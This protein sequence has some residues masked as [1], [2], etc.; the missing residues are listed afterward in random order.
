MN[1][2]GK[3]LLASIEFEKAVEINKFAI[4]PAVIAT[5]LM[6]AWM[7]SG[8][9]Q[10]VAEAMAQCDTLVDSAKEII[11]QLTELNE[12]YGFGHIQSDADKLIANLKLMVDLY[13]SIS[14]PISDKETDKN[15]LKTLKDNIS[16]FIVALSE[17]ETQLQL[18]SSYLTENKGW[19]T[20]STEAL[21]GVG[22]SFGLE[23]DTISAMRAISNFYVHVGAKRIELENT[24]KKLADKAKAQITQTPEMSL[25]NSFT[26]EEPE[27]GEELE[28]MPGALDTSTKSKLTSSNLEEFADINF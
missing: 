11:E 7:V 27:D 15:K 8:A 4:A 12:D 14:E 23:T 17:S 19:G 25:E 21:R 1:K 18:V 24:L 22:M 9:M 2:T 10:G 6:Y 20:K 26:N 13:P 28:P 3:I 5:Y 16:K